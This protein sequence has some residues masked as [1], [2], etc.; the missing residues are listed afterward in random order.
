[1]PVAFG[2]SSTSGRGGM[3]RHLTENGQDVDE[4]EARTWLDVDMATGASD[5]EDDT[6]NIQVGVAGGCSVWCG[7]MS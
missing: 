3:K 5:D 6:G 1:M 4:K 7:Y 2:K